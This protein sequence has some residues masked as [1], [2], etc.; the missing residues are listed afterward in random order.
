[1]T[2]AAQDRYSLSLGHRGHGSR[3]SVGDFDPSRPFPASNRQNF[4]ASQRFQGHPNRPSD[5]DQ[6][7]QAKKRLAQ[8]RER[9]LR[10]YHQEQQ[11]N[12]SEPT[13]FSPSTP[14]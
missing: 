7:F 13:S 3:H 1:M 5:V 2:N 14:Q 9:D 6:A 4:Y 12:R 10:N 11:Y 8:A